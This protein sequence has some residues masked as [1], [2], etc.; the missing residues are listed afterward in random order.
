M[1]RILTRSFRNPG[2][3]ERLYDLTTLCYLAFRRVHVRRSS[4]EYRMAWSGLR[5]PG[6]NRNDF[7]ET[8][9]LLEVV[10][11]ARVQRQVTRKCG[12]GDQKIERASTA[13]LERGGGHRCIKATVRSSGWF[14]HRQRLEGRLRALEPVLATRALL[15]VGG[16]MRTGRQLGQRHRRDREGLQGQIDGI[17]LSEIDH[18]RR[19]NEPALVLLSHAERAADRERQERVVSD[20]SP[21]SSDASAITIATASP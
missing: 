8:V 17:D 3:T 15:G 16:R 10:G 7:E 18:Y 6:R 21:G 12:G 11:L 13:C 1:I 9:G 5:L 19:V 20:E 2:P 4:A 14:V